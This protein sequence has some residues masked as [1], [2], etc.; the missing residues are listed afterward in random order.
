MT[1]AEFNTTNCYCYLREKYSSRMDA[2]Q[3]LNNRDSD[4]NPHFD[5]SDTS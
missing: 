5:L 2:C 1:Q 3:F 4:S